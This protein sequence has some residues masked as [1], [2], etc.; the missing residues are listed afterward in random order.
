MNDLN[1]ILANLKVL[2]RPEAVQK[3]EHFGIKTINAYGIYIPELRLMAKS[4]KINHD[5][6]MQ[7]WKMPIHE[8]KL[9]ATMIADAKQV[10]PE[11]ADELV[12]DFYSWDICDQCVGN[13]IEDAYFAYDKAIEWA[14]REEEFVRRAGFVTMARLAVSDKRAQDSKFEDF[15]PILLEK[16]NDGRNFVKKAVNWA[17]RQIG[18]RNLA[19]NSKTIDLCYKIYET[20]DK[21]ACW[22]AS[23]AIKELKEG[24]MVK[25]RQ[26]KV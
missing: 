22:I 3:M 23:D 21:T 17:I 16:S 7:L 12:N 25:R 10:T 1:E 6:A 24:K 18:K 20:G 19:L 13:L 8:T 9:L 15:F 2:S 5:L 26:G 14:K 4:I 11:M